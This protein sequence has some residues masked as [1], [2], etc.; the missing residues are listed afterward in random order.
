M[1]VYQFEGDTIPS[2]AH[3]KDV[4]DVLSKIDDTRRLLWIN[5]AETYP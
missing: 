1:V 5:T 4:N 3:L 2:I